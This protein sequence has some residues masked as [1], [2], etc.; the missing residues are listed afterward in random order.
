MIPV[1]GSNVRPGSEGYMIPQLLWGGV[2][3]AAVRVNR[4]GAPTVPPGKG[5]GVGVG[6]LPTAIQCKLAARGGRP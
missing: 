6:R 3:P 4:V 5:L 1:A 2:L